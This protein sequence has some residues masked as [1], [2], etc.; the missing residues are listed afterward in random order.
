MNNGRRHRSRID[1]TPAHRIDTEVETLQRAR[2]QQN[3]IAR[4][5][6]DDV[7]RGRG[8][9]G[10]HKSGPRPSVQDSAIRLTETRE[11]P[12]FNSQ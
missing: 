6:E 10:V 3:T 11:F 9:T 5:A 12:A 8:A 4:L 2:S 7:I 1:Q